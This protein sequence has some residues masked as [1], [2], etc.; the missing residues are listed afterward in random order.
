MLRTFGLS[1]TAVFLT[2]RD[3]AAVSYCT[4]GRAKILGLPEDYCQTQSFDGSP[5]VLVAI[6]GGM[7]AF[8]LLCYLCAKWSTKP[9]AKPPLK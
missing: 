9:P 1:L 2:V 6:F 7:M 3:A 5:L 4:P 8:W